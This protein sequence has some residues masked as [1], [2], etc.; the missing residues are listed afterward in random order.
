[1][2]FNTA[3]FVNDNLTTILSVSSVVGIISTGVLAFKAGQEIKELEDDEKTT[4]KYVKILSKPLLAGGATIVCIAGINYAYVK[5]YAALAGFYAMSQIDMEK[6][7]AKIREEFGEEKEKEVTDIV[8]RST[9][10]RIMFVDTDR[11]QTFYD[12]IT[13]RYFSSTV[14][15]I[16]MAAN[17]INTIIAYE[18]RA[19]LN[20]F[21]KE[22]GLEPVECGDLIQWHRGDAFDKL[23]IIYDTQMTKDYKAIMTIEYDMETQ[24]S[25]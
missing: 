23:E 12:R 15:K 11:E 24:Y 8:K 14:H 10:D 6:L 5:Q 3:K 20:E 7:K 18:G 22:L 19:N 21:Y 4:L 1:M 13:G 9:P 2:K 17:T 16:D 25:W